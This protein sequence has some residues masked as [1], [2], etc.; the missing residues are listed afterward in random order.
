MDVLSVWTQTVRAVPEERFR[1]GT[2]PQAWKPR[3]YRPETEDI[4]VDDDRFISE[5]LQTLIYLVP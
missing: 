1:L 3:P 5:Q 2:I 4:G